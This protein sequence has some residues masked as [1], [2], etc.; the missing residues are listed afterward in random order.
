[1]N[2]MLKC[3]LLVLLDAFVFIAKL[4]SGAVNSRANVGEKPLL[5]VAVELPFNFEF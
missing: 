4:R 1:M 3:I 2:E 5:A